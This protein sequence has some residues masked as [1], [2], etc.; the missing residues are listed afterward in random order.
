MGRGGSLDGNDDGNKVVVNVDHGVVVNDDL[1]GAASH[2]RSHQLVS[3]DCIEIQS[4]KFSSTSYVISHFEMK[5]KNI[6]NPSNFPNEITSSTR[7]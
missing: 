3:I 5:R 1:R 6:T 2:T 7:D 4:Y